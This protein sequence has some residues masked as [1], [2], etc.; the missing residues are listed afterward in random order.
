MQVGHPVPGP[1]RIWRV[2]PGRARGVFFRDGTVALSGGGSCLIALAHHSPR[3]RKSM[4]V[5]RGPDWP[6]HSRHF[7]PAALLRCAPPT[8]LRVLQNSLSAPYCGAGSLP[9]IRFYAYPCGR[10]QAPEAS[11]RSP[12]GL[13][14]RRDA[15]GCKHRA[16]EFCGTQLRAVSRTTTA[17]SD[18]RGETWKVDQQYRTSISQ[19]RSWFSDPRG[20][21]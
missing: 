18:R 19:C 17:P 10:G 12:R 9:A 15:A 8:I 20:S 4:S 13:G 14:T 5:L 3:A 16:A 11:P 21:R 2:R 6:F 7:S 1:A